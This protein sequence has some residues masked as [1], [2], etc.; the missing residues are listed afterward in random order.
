MQDSGYVIKDPAYNTYYC[1]YKTWDSQLRKAKI[2][3]SVKYAKEYMDSCDRNTE[4]KK[5]IIK[6]IDE[7]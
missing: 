5:I 7:S 6:E 2:Y 4:L 3:H 1:G